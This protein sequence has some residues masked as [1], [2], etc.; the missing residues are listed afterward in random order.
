[1]FSLLFLY[2]FPTNLNSKH[3]TKIIGN[4]AIDNKCK[5]IYRF[6]REDPILKE[7]KGVSPVSR[8]GMNRLKPTIMI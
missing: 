8:V 5:S 1:L 2:Y 6:R 7:F 4:Q 3:M